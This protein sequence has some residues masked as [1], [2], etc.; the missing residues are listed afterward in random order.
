MN[1]T[2]SDVFYH[3]II[4]AHRFIDRALD[5]LQLSEP[6]QS[7]H[8]MPCLK[9]GRLAALPEC[10]LAITMLISSVAVLSARSR[11]RMN[12]PHAILLCVSMLSTVTSSAER[13]EFEIFRRQGEEQMFLHIK[14][15]RGIPHTTFNE[16]FKYSMCRNADGG[17][18]GTG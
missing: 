4:C 16:C 5:V 6:S 9:L 15:L 3:K 14:L 17:T 11:W 8:P 10:F 7:L 12:A 13:L 1:R 18:D 2:N